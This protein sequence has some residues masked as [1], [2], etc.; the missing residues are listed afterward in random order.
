MR[1]DDEEVMEIMI[2]VLEEQDNIDIYDRDSIAEFIIN[3]MQRT[4]KEDDDIL[5][6][7]MEDEKIN[8]D[9]APETDIPKDELEERVQ[10]YND[11]ISETFTSIA[12]RKGMGDARRMAI[13]YI[14]GKMSG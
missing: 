4:L 9:T 5:F 7:S 12:V 14:K 8:W 1:L 11:I 3:S 10:E 2:E 6:D 13:D